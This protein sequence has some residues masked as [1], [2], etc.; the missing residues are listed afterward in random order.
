MK[1]VNQLVLMI[2]IFCWAG[3]VGAIFYSHIAVLPSILYHL[4]ESRVLENGPFPIKDEF[5]WKAIHP[6]VILFTMLALIFNWKN[7]QRRKLIGAAS[8]IY[9]IALIATFTFFV[10][11][12]ITMLKSNQNI[13]IT[14]SEWLARGE[15]WIKLSWIRGGFMFI[16]FFLLLQSL[17]KSDQNNF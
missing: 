7:I 8:I 4:P 9:I 13:S 11:E 17:T 15:R 16:G 3:I 14:K 5:F 12:L 1:K 2:A 6:I 10:P